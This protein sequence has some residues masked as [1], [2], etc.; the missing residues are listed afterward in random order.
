MRA[1]W[2]WIWYCNVLWEKQQNSH[3]TYGRGRREIL[4]R[5]TKID[6]G[7]FSKPTE[8]LEI[9]LL[10][11]TRAWSILRNG[12]RLRA[13]SQLRKD[14]AWRRVSFAGSIGS[15]FQIGPIRTRLSMPINPYCQLV[16]SWSA[17]NTN[18]TTFW[19]RLRLTNERHDSPSSS[20]WGGLTPCS[21]F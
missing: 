10:P 3:V 14:H 4:V 1:W 18:D 8:C 21:P 5:R 15:P 19:T 6:C 2:W 17:V 20:F 7:Y 11:L 9:R 12:S 16:G 13:W